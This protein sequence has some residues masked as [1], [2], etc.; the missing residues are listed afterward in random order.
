MSAGARTGATGSPGFTVVG[1]VT[2]A[3][4]S[5]SNAADVYVHDARIDVDRAVD[6]IGAAGGT[7]KSPGVFSP[8]SAPAGRYEQQQR[9]SSSPSL[10]SPSGGVGVGVG[11][12]AGAGRTND[13]RRASAST[14]CHSYREYLHDLRRREKPLSYYWP[15]R[16]SRSL[17][18]LQSSTSSRDLLA[19]A[20]NSSGFLGGAYSIDQ[21]EGG[22]VA[23]RQGNA[24]HSQAANP[25]VRRGS[26]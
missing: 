14:G 7:I 2:R 1:S 24:A 10:V 6:G 4:R 15:A 21:L 26:G 8:S 11:V 13:A 16:S 25:R 22:T 19:N 17:S 20:P 9:R 12:S 23:P 5:P 18:L 3:E